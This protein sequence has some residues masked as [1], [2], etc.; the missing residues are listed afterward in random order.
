[1]FNFATYSTQYRSSKVLGGA[2]VA[3]A[4]SFRTLFCGPDPADPQ[5]VLV[6]KILE[7]NDGRYAYEE[8]TITPQADSAPSV[9]TKAYK[10]GHWNLKEDA[11]Q[12]EV[13]TRLLF[14]PQPTSVAYSLYYRKTGA[15]SNH[16]SIVENSI[17]K[18]AG[19]WFEMFQDW[20]D[21]RDLSRYLRYRWMFN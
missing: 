18:P 7:L 13:N 10:I 4:T 19:T 3:D 2:D 8:T 12:K 6:R 16:L 17:Y 14:R 9:H 20:K 5:R 1:M 21:R 11:T 15:G